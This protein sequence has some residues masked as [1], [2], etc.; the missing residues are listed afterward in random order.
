MVGTDTHAHSHTH[1]VVTNLAR[2]SPR[3]QKFNSGYKREQR[4][5]GRKKERERKYRGKKKV[6]TRRIPAWSPTAV[7]TTPVVV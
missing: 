2:E 4:D 5:T 7:L 1:T 3:D 6:T